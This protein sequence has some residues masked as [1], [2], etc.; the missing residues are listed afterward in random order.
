MHSL[1]AEPPSGERVLVDTRDALAQAAD[2]IGRAGALALDVEAGKPRGAPAAVAALIQIA[3][4]TH[5]WLIDPLLLQGRLVPLDEALRAR[6]Q[7]I[8]LFDAP[9]DVRWLESCG[10]RVA[11]ATDLLQVTRSAYGEQDKSLL[12]ALRRHFRVAVDKSGQQADWLA[13]PI[14]G[15]LRHYAARDAELTLALARRYADLFPDLMAIHT[16]AGGRVSLPEGL[17]AWVTRVLAGDRAPAYALAEQDGLPIDQE[18]SIGPLIAASEQAL[19]AI[20]VPRL[21]AR[22]Y[23][24]IANLD[25]IELAPRV[26]A[27]LTSPCAVERAAAARALGEL[28]AVDFGDAL[29]ALS[30]DPVPDVA[31]AAERARLA[32]SGDD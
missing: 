25:L 28:N 5:T 24:A 7:P 4:E 26:A 12:D 21:R 17:P 2:E 31:R 6:S 16:Y 29:A 3:S 32:L 23:R 30:S 15:P 14:P 8:A 1:L 10:V 18:T 11:A 13:R 20:S 9:G 22:L 27:G 19:E